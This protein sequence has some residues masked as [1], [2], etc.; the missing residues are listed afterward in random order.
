MSEDQPANHRLGP[1]R[2][3]V[4]FGTRAASATLRPIVG[5]VEAAADAG[6]GLERRAVSRV[7][8]S[9]ELER[10]VVVAINSTHIQAALRQAL[11]SDGA[12]QLVDTVFDSGLMDRVFE[13]LLESEALWHLIDEIASSPAVTAAISQQGLGFADEVGDQVRSRSRKA[14]DWMERSARRLVGR[15]PR[16]LPAEPG[17]ST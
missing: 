8:E 16:A 1:L 15:K 3:F 2:P 5:I 6:A 12:M 11:G 13:R 7:L 9:N 10:V 4:G 17:A 14:D